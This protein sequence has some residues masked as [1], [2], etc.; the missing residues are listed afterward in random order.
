MEK[1]IPSISALATSAVLPAVESKI[2]NV[3]NLV[4]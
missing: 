2:P 1:K 3:S 4:K